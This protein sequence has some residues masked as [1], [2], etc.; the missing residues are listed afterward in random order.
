MIK[1]LPVSQ[2]TS[3]NKDFTQEQCKTKQLFTTYFNPKENY[4]KLIYC[5]P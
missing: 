5:I 4:L 2:V 3:M 1:Y